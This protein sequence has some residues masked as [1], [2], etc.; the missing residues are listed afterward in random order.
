MNR[1][2]IVIPMRNSGS[3]IG[4]VIN[5][6]NSAQGISS[7]DLIILDN[8]SSD[9]SVE[10]TNFAFSN[11]ELM[12][13][14]KSV[15]QNKM[16]LGYGGSLIEGLSWGLAK[17]YDWF[18]VL[19]S[20]DQADWKR[21]FESL[22]EVVNR[23][24]CEV[25]LTSR[26]H[27]NARYAGYSKRRVVGNLIFKVITKITIG[28][29]ITDPGAAVCAISKNALTQVPFLDL[30]R[31]YHFHP[32]FNVYLNFCSNIRIIEVPISWKNATTS[33][34][35]SLISYGLGLLRFLVAFSF[36]HRVKGLSLNASLRQA[37]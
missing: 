23:G 7:A 9:N 10:I 1:K 37:N 33:E 11:S 35:F 8:D 18:Y 3:M 13:G 31:N 21:V 34:R 26:F 28:T 32:Q 12:T 6:L 20:D 36:Y 2:L 30:D 5:E 16:N 15:I 24:E 29:K 19:H 22:D 25:V 17:N 27:A 14:D 4:K